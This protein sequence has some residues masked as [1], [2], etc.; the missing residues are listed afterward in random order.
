M[1]PRRR[2]KATC[3]ICKAVIEAGEFTCGEKICEMAALEGQAM[4]AP[5][6]VEQE[7]RA[8]RRVRFQPSLSLP[9]DLEPA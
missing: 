2:K 5:L 4:L 9:P 8:A 1:M 6:I 3:L 7:V